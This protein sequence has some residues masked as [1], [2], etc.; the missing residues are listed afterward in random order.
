MDLVAFEY[1][2]TRLCFAT[3]F[4]E[5]ISPSLFTRESFRLNMRDRDKPNFSSRA[6]NTRGASWKHS[7]S[8]ETG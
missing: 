6:K 2:R 1:A 5:S 4:V 3:H 7:Q 8:A